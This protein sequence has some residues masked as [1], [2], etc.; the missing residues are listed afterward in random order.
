[1]NRFLS[2]LGMG[3]AL[4]F[5]FFYFLIIVFLESNVQLLMNSETVNT[6]VLI[7]SEITEGGSFDSKCVLSHFVDGGIAFIIN[8][9][10]LWSSRAARRLKFLQSGSQ[11]SYIFSD[12]GKAREAI[13]SVI[14]CV[15]CDKHISFIVEQTLSLH[16]ICNIHLHNHS[17]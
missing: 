2:P 6:S 17:F 12:Q 5:F 11:I 3:S 4:H 14:T 10:K 15:V 8:M 7:V 1:M 16:L 13:D 9:K